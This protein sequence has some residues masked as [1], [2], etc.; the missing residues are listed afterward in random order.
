MFRA[1]LAIGGFGLVVFGGQLSV[2]VASG[3]LTRLKTD[4]TNEMEAW[5]M[6]DGSEATGI[7]ALCFLKP[8]S[9]AVPP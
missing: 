6:T 9:V 5:L 4:F 3:F 7:R 2:P 1:G 8:P